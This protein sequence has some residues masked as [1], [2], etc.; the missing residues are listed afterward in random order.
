MT[1]HDRPTVEVPALSVRRP[2]YQHLVAAL[3]IIAALAGSALGVGYAGTR[4]QTAQE[5]ACKKAE[6]ASKSESF[7]LSDVEF[8]L[9]KEQERKEQ[10]MLLRH[11]QAVQACFTDGGIPIMGF[12]FEVVCM[13]KVHVRWTHS[14][15]EPLPWL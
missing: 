13:S 12:D 8:T 15:K 7:R 14:L 10:E 6:E 9:R 1:E 5:T 2:W 4:M 3:C 11:Q